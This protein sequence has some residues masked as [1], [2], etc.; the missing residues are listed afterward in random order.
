M[1]NL[2]IWNALKQPP[3]E[4]LK[5]I[6][7]GRLKGKTDINPQWRYKAMTE[8]FGVCGVGWKYT[9]EKLWLEPSGDEI[10]AFAA[11]GLSIKVNGEWSDPTPGIGGSMILAKES[12]GLHVNDECY[13]MAIT[14]A[15]SVA[16]KM[17]GVA[18][19]IYAGL[20]DGSRYIG[21]KQPAQK[22]T[23]ARQATTPPESEKEEPPKCFID[24]T[25]LA[26]SLTTL[27]T[28]QIK[29]WDEKALLS[30]M[31]TTYQVEGDTVV[32]AASKLDKGKA[33][34]FVKRIEEAIER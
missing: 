31:K 14:D 8:Q 4:A 30:F 16:M 18:A 12:S 11:I 1:E 13:K 5:T 29:G 10:C 32:E 3:Q 7:G 23:P 28:K 34:H 24:L 19:D 33:A 20:F 25:W 6:Q 15:L 9:I 22:T 27:R 21:D 26:D 2:T 17:I